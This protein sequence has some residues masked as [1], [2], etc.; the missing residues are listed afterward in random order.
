[1]EQDGPRAVGTFLVEVEDLPHLR[2]VVKVMRRVK[3]VDEVRRVD[4]ADGGG[5]APRSA[6]QTT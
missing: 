5:S 6:A 3:G 4:H 1:M 2:R